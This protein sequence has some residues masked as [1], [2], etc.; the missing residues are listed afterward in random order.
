MTMPETSSNLDL[1]RAL[2]DV[3]QELWSNSDQIE[4]RVKI[5]EEEVGRWKDR[6]DAAIRRG[7]SLSTRR[8]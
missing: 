1:S 5:G 8:A 4:G 2:D 6:P 7:R 3:C